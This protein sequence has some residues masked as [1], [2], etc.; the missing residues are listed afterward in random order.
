MRVFLASP[1][2]SLT[3]LNSTA[4]FTCSARSDLVE[5]LLWEVDGGQTSSPGYAQLLRDKGLQWNL[6]DDSL[7]KVLELTVFASM[8]NNETKIMC[9]AFT[10][11]GNI[12]KTTAVL[13]TVYGRLMYDG[14]YI[15]M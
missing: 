5:E 12:I 2:P 7:W 9:V 8:S 1:H 10:T 13:L 6:T 15:K 14:S 3:P 11:S 4:T